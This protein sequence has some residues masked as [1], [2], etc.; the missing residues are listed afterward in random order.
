MLRLRNSK[1][2]TYRANF[3]AAVDADNVLRDDWTAYWDFVS[4]YLAS[5]GMD[6][7]NFLG[8][9][10]DPRDAY[11]A[12]VAGGLI[13][14]NVWSGQAWE[15]MSDSQREQCRGF[16]KKI[17]SRF[18]VLFQQ[19]HNITDA[20]NISLPGLGDGGEGGRTNEPAVHD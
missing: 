4:G 12:V 11:S 16:A 20:G 8:N 19:W 2:S 13:P 9:N 5:R 6:L 18:E 15:G 14:Y 17:R 1:P 7:A 3:Q 10:T